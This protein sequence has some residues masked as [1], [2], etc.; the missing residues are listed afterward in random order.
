MVQGGGLSVCH[1]LS[2]DP[3]WT[4][5]KGFL[6]A[7]MIKRLAPDFAE[8]DAFL[9]GPPPMVASVSA[10]LTGLGMSVT[11]IHSEVFSL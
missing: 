8:R 1:V 10:A 7:E 2:G 5:E 3:D 11:R 4:G 6:D 9:C